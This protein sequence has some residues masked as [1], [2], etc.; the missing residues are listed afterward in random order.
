VVQFQPLGDRE[1][2][3]VEIESQWTATRRECG[4]TETHVSKARH[5]A[6]AFVIN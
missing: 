4:I 5:G 2:G 1:I 6:P 3:T